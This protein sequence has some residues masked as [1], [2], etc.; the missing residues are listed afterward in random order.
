MAERHSCAP[1]LQVRGASDDALR[2][3]LSTNVPPRTPCPT[4]QL[5]AQTTFPNS[6]AV[7]LELADRRRSMPAE[8]LG[9]DFKPDAA[10]HPTLGDVI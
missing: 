10:P 5:A 4:G 9:D 7:L 3:L 6:K 2:K 1:A 8:S